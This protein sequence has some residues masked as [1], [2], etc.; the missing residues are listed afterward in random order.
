MAR[1][2]PREM[3][4]IAREEVPFVGQLGIRFEHIEDGT[5]RAVLPSVRPRAARRCRLRRAPP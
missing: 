2:D 1:I 3:E 5:A 4:R